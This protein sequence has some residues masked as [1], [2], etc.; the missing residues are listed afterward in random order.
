MTDCFEPC[1]KEL[2]I[3]PRATSR[4]LAAAVRIIYGGTPS[5]KTGIDPA[6]KKLCE[7]IV[8]SHEK[9]SS[10]FALF[11]RETGDFMTDLAHELVALIRLFKFEKQELERLCRRNEAD[12][13]KLEMACQEK[14]ASHSAWGSFH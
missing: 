3:S 9:F 7:F 6:R 1:I 10:H 5:S 2:S 11:Q 12:K 8:K 4:C 14:Q 13:K